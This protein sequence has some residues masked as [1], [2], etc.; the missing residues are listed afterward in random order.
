[1]EIGCRSQEIE[2]TKQALLVLVL[3]LDSILQKQQKKRIFTVLDLKHGYHQM[4]L[5]EDC[6]P[7]TATS[8]PLGPLQWNEVPMGAKNGNAAFQCIMEDLLQAVCADLFVDSSIIGWVTEDMTGE[9]LI[10]AHEKDFTRGLRVLDR[11]SMVCQPTKA[12]PSVREVEFAGHVVGHGQRPPVLGILPPLCHWKEPQTISEPRFFVG[13]CNYYSGNA[14]MYADLSGPLHK[15]LQVG[16]FVVRKGS[17]K[18]LAW[19]TEAVE[20]FEKLKEQQWGQLGHFLVDLDKSFLLRTEASEYA[21]G[22]VGEKVRCDRTHVPVAF[23]V[24]ALA[25]GQRRKWTAGEEETSAIV[26]T[27]RKCM[28]GPDRTSTRG[29]MHQSS[30]TSELAQ[31]ACRYHPKQALDGHV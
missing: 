7:C 11:H 6:R 29:G 15:M 31:G 4:L 10:E 30:I 20:S 26:C 3:V 8:T 24:R 28:V 13:F 25:E 12:S 1:M 18:K 9:K 21:V 22:V 19:T 16:K 5:H 14:R 23:W 27:L 2:R 17:K